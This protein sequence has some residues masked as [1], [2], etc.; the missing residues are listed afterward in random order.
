MEEAN[1]KIKFFLNIMQSY[2]TELIIKIEHK[3]AKNRK[4]QSPLNLVKK[5]TL[6]NQY[7]NGSKDF[8]YDFF[9]GKHA[10]AYNLWGQVLD[11]LLKLV[12]I[13]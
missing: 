7:Y 6:K 10:K 8:A 5:K 1:H 2:I 12:L 13:L 11:Q 4:I 3:V 9:S